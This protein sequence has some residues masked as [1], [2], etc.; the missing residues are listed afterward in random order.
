MKKE[1]TFKIPFYQQLKILNI[2]S[3]TITH[4]SPL[5]IFVKILLTN[6]KIRQQHRGLS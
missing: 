5:I 6:I 4:L 3:R 2:K 1:K